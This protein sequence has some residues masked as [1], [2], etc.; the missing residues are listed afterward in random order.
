MFF[1]ITSKSH[2]IEMPSVSF[3]ALMGIHLLI[4]AIY[5]WHC[6]ATST[7]TKTFLSER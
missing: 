4:L 7:I 3:M 5:Y 1:G 6:K 2:F